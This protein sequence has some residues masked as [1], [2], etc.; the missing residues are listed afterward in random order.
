M[1]FSYVLYG[2]ASK[3]VCDL[4]SGTRNFRARFLQW[5]RAGF[6]P[7]ET[8]QERHRPSIVLIQ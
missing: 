2:K 7:Q 6:F 5:V 3:T 1:H 8:N 4:I